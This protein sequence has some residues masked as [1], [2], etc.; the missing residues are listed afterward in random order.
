[1]H[2]FDHKLMCDEGRGRKN[3]CAKGVQEIWI[4]AIIHIVQPRFCRCIE[5]PEAPQCIASRPVT[6]K[7]PINLDV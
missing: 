1:M 4:A 3:T 6:A 5:E 2:S 7:A